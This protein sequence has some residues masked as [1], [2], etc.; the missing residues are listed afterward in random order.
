M[1]RRPLTAF[2]FNWQRKRVSILAARR[3][4]VIDDDD[5]D[6]DDDNGDVYLD[7]M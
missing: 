5:D 7:G 6:D 2:D 3:N 4:K 1:G